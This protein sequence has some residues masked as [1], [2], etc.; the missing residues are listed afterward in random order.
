MF[1]VIAI[2]ILS[3]S[4]S[5]MFASA[6]PQ[7]PLRTRVNLILVPVTVTDRRGATVNGL[8]RENFTILE[9]NTPQNILSFSIQ[10]APCSVGIILDASGSMLRTMRDAKIVAERF[11]TAA[12]PEDDFFLLTVSTRPASYSGFTSDLDALWKD[13]LLTKP[14]GRTAL[15][16]T[17]YLGVNRVRSAR[18][19]RRALLIVSDGM[20]NYSRF[21]HSELMRVAMETDVQIYTVAMGEFP[22]NR[23]PIELQEERHGRS[24]LRDV[25]QK[26]GGLYFEATRPADVDEV[27]TNIGRAVRNQYVI[28]YQRPD[29]GGA[30]RW[31]SI[32]VKLNG[33]NANVNTRNGYYR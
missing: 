22:R 20:D 3:A 14:G 11:L 17:I 2:V 31:H 30:E 27:A 13:V 12:N 9:D 32:K 19:H 10:E 23:K 6:G 1:A 5:Q 16:D 18:N 29:G 15:I 24:L 8:A 26:T 33:S 25:A 21:T 28:G 4:V 7:D